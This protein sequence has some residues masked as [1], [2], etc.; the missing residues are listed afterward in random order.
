MILT[1]VELI[2]MIKTFGAKKVLNMYANRKINISATQR[3][4]L[5]EIQN[6]TKEIKYNKIVKVEEKECTK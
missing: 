5:I 2:K 6:G 3:N 4:D 1:N